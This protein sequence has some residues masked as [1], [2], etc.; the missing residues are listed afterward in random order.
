MC[1]ATVG[2]RASSSVRRRT[3]QCRGRARPRTRPFR[4]NGSGPGSRRARR[5]GASSQINGRLVLDGEIVAG[6]R[7]LRAT[8]RL[9]PPGTPRSGRR[10]HRGQARRSRSGQRRRDRSPRAVIQ[11]APR[12]TIEVVVRRPPAARDRTSPARDLAHVDAGCV[13]RS[14]TPRLAAGRGTRPGSSARRGDDLDAVREAPAALGDRGRMIE[15]PGGPRCRAPRAGRRAT[16]PATSPARSAP[17][18]PGL[19]LPSARTGLREVAR[20]R[21][22]QRVRIATTSAPGRVRP[23]EPLLAGDREV[24]ESGRADRD[25]AHRLGTVDEHGDA[26]LLAELAHGQDAPRRPDHL[27]QREQPRP[28]R[29]GGGI[30]SGSGATTTTLA[31]DVASGPSRPKCSSVVVTISSSGS[32]PSPPRTMLQPSVVLRERHLQ[33][34]PDQ[35]REARPQLLA[36]V[37]HPL[38]VRPPRSPVARSRSSA[39]RIA[40]TWCARAGRTC[41]R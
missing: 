28:G 7:P 37:Q 23:A 32:S 14:T 35:R 24:V 2:L 20:R 38:E 11:A 26:G 18:R 6:R 31:P 41:R 4:R 30:A 33:G 27:G 40:S 10:S 12:A 5:P 34:P 13:E 8:A 36:Q 1:A 9:S 15:G 16:Q 21:D 39:A 22:P 3:R 17:P 25:R 29:D 19:E